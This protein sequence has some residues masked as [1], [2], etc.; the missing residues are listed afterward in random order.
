MP[1]PN[2]KKQPSKEGET[3]RSNQGKALIDQQ[4]GNSGA[5]H[6]QPGIDRAELIMLKGR[7]GKVN[8]E[9]KN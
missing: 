4:V 6:K 9:V 7:E 1:K 3:C 2:Q 5:S 8:V